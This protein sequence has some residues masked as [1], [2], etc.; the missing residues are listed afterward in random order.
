VPGARLP[1]W[2]AGLVRPASPDWQPLAASRPARS[3]PAESPRS[4]GGRIRS[5]GPASRPWPRDGSNGTKVPAAWA[6]PEPWVTRKPVEVAPHARPG[7]W[8]EAAAWRMRPPR[9]LPPAPRPTCLRYP[10]RG[11]NLRLPIPGPRACP[12]GPKIATVPPWRPWRS[13]SWPRQRP[14]PMRATCG[15]GRAPLPVQTGRW[16]GEVGCPL[17][18]PRRQ[19]SGPPA[20]GR[21]PVRARP[22]PKPPIRRR[23]P[24]R[25]RRPPHRLDPSSSRP[26][27]TG[28]LPRSCW[29]PQIHWWLRERGPR[30]CLVIAR[31]PRPQRPGP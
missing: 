11:T 5:V 4:E 25:G 8:M 1:A 16:P 14:E 12:T 19:R 17:A 24:P 2:R 21:S 18:L 3:V 26:G 9:P 15:R 23:R 13:T 29:C 10:G 7:V 30:N 27:G 20:R 6:L 28:D 31:G 22:R